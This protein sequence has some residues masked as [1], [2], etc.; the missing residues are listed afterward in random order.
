MKELQGILNAMEPAE[1]LS[2][3]TPQLRKIL[4]HLDE[5]ARVGFVA[6]LINETAGDKLSSMVHL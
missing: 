4:S 3:L 1:A 2:A 5:E 6:S